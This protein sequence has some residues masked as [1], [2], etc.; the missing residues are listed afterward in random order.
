[1]LKLLLNFSVESM[2][3]SFMYSV[4]TTEAYK[5]PFIGSISFQRGYTFVAEAVIPD[6]LPVSAKWRMRLIGEKELLPKLSHEPP[7]S[8]FSVREFQDYYIPDKKSII[9]R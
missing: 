1:M 6:S 2:D 4:W 9:C 8:T 7:L 5:N 3:S